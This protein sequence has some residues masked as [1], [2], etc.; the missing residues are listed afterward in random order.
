[1]GTGCLGKV[2][3]GGGCLATAEA[4]AEALAG[5]DAEALAGVE[6]LASAGAGAGGVGGSAGGEAGDEASARGLATGVAGGA[7]NVPAKVPK[8]A[9]V[10]TSQ[11]DAGRGLPFPDMGNVRCRTERA[12]DV[13]VSGPYSKDV[14]AACRRFT[15]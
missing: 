6:A 10:R 12:R 13:R 2:S 15:R 3:F 8:A 9:I 7:Q 14:P 5:A 4:G 11:R 1:M